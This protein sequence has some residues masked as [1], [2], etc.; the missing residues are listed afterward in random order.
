MSFKALPAGFNHG[1]T[2]FLPKNVE[3]DAILTVQKKSAETR[4]LFL[5]NTDNKICSSLVCIPFG[6]QCRYSV[7]ENQT[8]FIKGRSMFDNIMKIEAHVL[9]H[10]VFQDTNRAG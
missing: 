4:P 5:S 8:G 7:H 6:Q 1:T 9:E 10:S 2:V 3:D